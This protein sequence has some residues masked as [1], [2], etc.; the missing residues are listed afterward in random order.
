MYAVK[1]FPEVDEI[2]HHRFLPRR[3]FFDDLP[4]CEYLV[5]ARS[6]WPE[7]CLFL[8]A[9]YVQLMLL[10]GRPDAH[11]LMPRA[12]TSANLVMGWIRIM[13]GHP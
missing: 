8:T 2:Y 9:R 10:R 5:I 7:S 6:S 3:Y 11:L 13:A 12:V 4:H 1:G